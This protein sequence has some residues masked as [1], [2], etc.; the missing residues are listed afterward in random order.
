MEFSSDLTAKACTGNLTA[1]QDLKQALAGLSA[2]EAFAHLAKAVPSYAGSH[3][4][5]VPASGL[6]QAARSRGR[7]FVETG[8]A[9]LAFTNPA[10]RVI[11]E[12]NQRDL[13]WRTRTAFVANIGRARVHGYSGVIESDGDALIDAED[14]EFAAVDDDLSFD[15]RVFRS[16]GRDVWHISSAGR[17]PDLRL[18]Q[19]FSL[20]GPHSDAFGHWIWEYLPRL[21]AAIATGILPPMA[22][23]V[24]DFIPPTHRQA[25]AALLPPGWTVVDVPFNACVEVENLWCAPSLIYMPVCEVPGPRSGW[26]YMAS[27]VDRYLAAINV[28]RQKFDSAAPPAPPVRKIFLSRH[29]ISRRKLVNRDEVE[30]ACAAHGYDIIIPERLSFD[31]QVALVRSASHIIAPEGS[32]TLLCYYARPGTRLLMLSHPDTI[33]QATLTPILD[34]LGVETT[35]LTGPVVKR[36]PVWSHFSHYRID[37]DSLKRFFHGDHGPW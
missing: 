5:Q 15:P 7:P 16:D 12:G 6:A 4:R 13:H 14:W 9:R 37:V 35:I 36:H 26:D 10:P 22:V 8:A 32:A 28:M 23:L 34:A 25:L 2:E 27:P 17:E 21:A 33:G 20:L 11:G 3:L 29:Q 18:P 1:L 19:A 30:Q 31:D 24:E